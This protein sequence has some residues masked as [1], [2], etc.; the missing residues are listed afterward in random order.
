MK[1]DYPEYYEMI[2]DLR[3]SLENGKKD[4]L[5]NRFLKDY[6]CLNSLISGGVYYSRY[7][8]MKKGA[9]EVK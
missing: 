8:Q 7:P 3:E 4:L 2:R 1:E 9:G 6:D 5:R